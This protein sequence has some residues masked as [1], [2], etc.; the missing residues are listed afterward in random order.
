MANPNPKT[1]NAPVGRRARVNQENTA[2]RFCYPS[3][4]SVKGRV[5][6]DLLRGHQL[7]HLDS[8]IE[9]GTSRLAA[10]IHILRGLGWP[11]HVDD[12]T[13][14]TS[15][16]RKAQIARYTLPLEVIVETGDRGLAFIDAVRRHFKGGAQ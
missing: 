11:I 4:D 3:S 15:D 10:H 8:W 2:Q 16:C 5:L 1:P 9:H 12:I 7:T 13:V 14:V 6:A